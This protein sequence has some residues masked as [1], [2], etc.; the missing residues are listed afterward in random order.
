MKL[1]ILLFLLA[2]LP[3]QAED[4]IVNGKM[5]SKV[6]VEKVEADSVT[7]LDSDGGARIPLADLSLSLQKK[8]NYDPIKAQ[9]AMAQRA[10]DD[11]AASDAIAKEKVREVQDE[12]EQAARRIALEQATKDQLARDATD[13]ELQKQMKTLAKHL[14][15]ING[16]IIQKT[17]S[18]YIVQANGP[19]PLE[20]GA[21]VDFSGPEWKA[22]QR[23][24]SDGIPILND[25]TVFVTSSQDLVDGDAISTN[26]FLVGEMSYQTV[27]G[28]EKTVRKYVEYSGPITL[29]NSNATASSDFN[30][31][32]MNPPH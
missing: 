25:A 12:V 15:H 17:S 29:G 22:A 31:G 28:S 1:P 11:R 4:W 30:P 20:P 5:Y 2:S 21:P 14:V 19:V 8:F 32:S 3:I 6:I 24:T 7:I 16:T 26:V 23:Y 18:G 10:S 13:A 9:A 27:L